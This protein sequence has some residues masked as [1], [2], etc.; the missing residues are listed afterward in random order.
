MLSWYI[1]I[2]KNIDDA[3]LANLDS[4]H[5]GMVEKSTDVFSGSKFHF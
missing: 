3:S 4:D 1:I 2:Q 5:F